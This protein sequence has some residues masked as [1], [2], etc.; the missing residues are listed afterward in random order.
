MNT[1]KNII[2]ITFMIFMCLPFQAANAQS[3]SSSLSQLA[4]VPDFSDEL[5]KEE[6]IKGS[7]LFEET[8]HNDKYLAYEIRLPEGWRKSDD[9]SFNTKKT[10]DMDFLQP[11]QAQVKEPEPEIGLSRR[12]LGEVASYNGPVK[13]GSNSK[14]DIYALELD[15][16]ITARNWLVNHV[17]SNGFS[18][19][20]MKAINDRRVEAAYITLVGDTSYFVRMIAEINGPR[21]IL[22]KYSVPE[23][24]FQEERAWQQYALESFEFTN[25]EKNRIEMTRT[26]NFLEL[27]EF[28][29]PA[30]WRLVA[31]NIYSVDGMEAK[32]INTKNDKTLSGEIK[33]VIVSTELD[34]S[35]SQE[36]KYAREDLM[37]MGLT[38]GKLLGVVDNYDFNPF[39]LFHRV[40]VYEAKDRTN[41]IVDHEYWI[42]VMLEDRYYYIVSMLTPGRDADFYGWARN[43]EAF[44]TVVES[45]TP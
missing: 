20:G 29:Y 15:H 8:P 36:V 28:E 39:I 22:I 10:N 19:M 9:H 26:Y 31:P 45:F 32:L 11:Q 24:Y 3:A 30:S 17:L 37:A 41:R 34:T 27:L 14:I 23:R 18:L 33:I 38:P 7:K 13:L 2:Y 1:I 6:F 40:E 25:P 16:E 42:A 43:T 44:Q 35:V 5:T 21:I 12:L 4:P